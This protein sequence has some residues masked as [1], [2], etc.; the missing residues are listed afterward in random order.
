LALEAA[1]AVDA[2]DVTGTAAVGALFVDA[3]V[4]G[5]L[6]VAEGVELT[7]ARVPAIPTNDTMLSPPSSQR[8]AAA[9]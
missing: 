8:V 4:A 6:A 5:A 9:G 1:V 2:F 3:T 7:E